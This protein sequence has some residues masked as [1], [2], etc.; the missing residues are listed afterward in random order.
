MPVLIVMAV[1][2]EAVDGEVMAMHIETLATFDQ[3]IWAAEKRRDVCLREIEH[4]RA[5][6]WASPASRSH[7]SR[8]AQCSGRRGAGRAEESG[9]TMPTPLQ[10]AANQ[11]AGPA[12]A[13]ARSLGRK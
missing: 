13:A 5:T 11:P 12:V 2:A 6:F 8:R 10:V 3:L 9:L 7:V 4:L 1:S